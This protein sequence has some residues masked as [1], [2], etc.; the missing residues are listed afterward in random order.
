MGQLLSPPGL[1]L[2][3]LRVSRRSAVIPRLSW[4]LLVRLRPQLDRRWLTLAAG[5]AVLAA[6]W[7]PAIGTFS[8]TMWTPQ[9]WAD[10]L[11]TLW[12]MAAGVTAALLLARL[13]AR[14]RIGP[15]RLVPEIPPVPQAPPVS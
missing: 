11:N 9:S 6:L 12:L 2:V 1:P 8:F 15:G 3:A 10:R 13:L 5:I 4:A 14:K 7:F